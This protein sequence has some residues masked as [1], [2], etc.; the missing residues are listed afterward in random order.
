MKRYKI[1]KEL[2]VKEGTLHAGS[3]ITLVGNRLFYNGGMVEPVFYN[4]LMDLIEYEN[5]KGHKYLKE[6]PIPFNK[7]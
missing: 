7:I 1:V 3:E 4:L 5:V 2:K 6:I